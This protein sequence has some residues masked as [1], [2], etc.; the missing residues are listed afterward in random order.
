MVETSCDDFLLLNSE[1]WFTC[2][3]DFQRMAGGLFAVSKKY[4]EYLGSYDIGMKLGVEKTS[5]SSFL[6]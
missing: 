6:G 1:L 4:F 5:N 3:C 2:F